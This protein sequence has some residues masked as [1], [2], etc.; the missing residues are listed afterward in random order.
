MKRNLSKSDWNSMFSNYND[1]YSS[2]EISSD[3][4]LILTIV[5][6]LLLYIVLL[7]PNLLLLFFSMFSSD[8]EKRSNYFEKVFLEP[9]KI[10][11]TIL[12]WLFEAPVT[13]YLILFLVFMYFVEI[14]YFVNIEG[15]MNSLMDY[16]LHFFQGNYYSVLTSIF[17]HANWIHLSTNCLALLIFGR[18]VEKEFGFKTLYIFIFSGIIANIVSNIIS[19][20]QNDLFYSL[21]ASGAIAG[22][23]IFAILVH[24]FSFTSFFIVPIPIFVLGWVLILVDILGVTKESTTNH[25]AHIGGYSALLILFFFFEIKNRKKII[26]G[27]SLNLILLL[28]VYLI[29]KF[30]DLTNLLNYIPIS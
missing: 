2:D 25:L 22:L 13:A 3:L 28:I 7:I 26:T 8:D 10:I 29:S 5:K 1:K 19:Y 15:L 21:G 30:V 14:I 12:N 18:Q 6:D 16:Q 9:F 4:M 27:F 24:P 11:M 20:L 17:L 23:I